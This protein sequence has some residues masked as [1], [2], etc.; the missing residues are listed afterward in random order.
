MSNKILVAITAAVAIGLAGTGFLLGHVKKGPAVTDANT[1]ITVFGV[2]TEKHTVAVI[3]VTKD[4]KV[5]P[6]I[7]PLS[8]EQIATLKALSDKIPIDNQ[9]VLTVIPDPAS[10]QGETNT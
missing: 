6:M 3:V 5:H 4:G 9:G 10:H 2:R 1:P 8:P 7:A